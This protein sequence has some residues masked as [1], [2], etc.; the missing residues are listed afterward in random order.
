MIFL[1]FILL[2]IKRKTYI[3]IAYLLL[4]YVRKKKK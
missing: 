2:I 1:E 3:K 4:K